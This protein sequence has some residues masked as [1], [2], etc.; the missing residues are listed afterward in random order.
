MTGSEL[1]ACSLDDSQAEIIAR[2]DRIEGKVD[3][4]NG[5]V[6]D[7]ESR[8]EIAD[9][10]RA[11]ISAQVESIRQHSLGEI[12]DAIERV[13][14]RRET[15]ADA[16]A[17]RALKDRFG[18]PEVGLGRW[19]AVTRLF[20]TTASKVWLMAVTSAAAGGIAVALER[21]F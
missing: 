3:H 14:N 12:E 4:T 1:P 6:R 11:G 19:Q 8:M 10:D 13:L 18:D 16:A 7:L 15:D 2:L 21:L 5:R 20:E 17:Y 9:R